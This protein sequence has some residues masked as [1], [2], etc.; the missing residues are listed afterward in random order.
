MSDKENILREDKK[1]HPKCEYSTQQRKT[2][3]LLL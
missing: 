2:V 3:F 1:S